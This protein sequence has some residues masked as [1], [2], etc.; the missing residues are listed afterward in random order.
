MQLRTPPKV[1]FAIEG[2]VPESQVRLLLAEAKRQSGVLTEA[3]SFQRLSQGRR[4]ARVGDFEFVC[5]SVF[6]L[7][8]VVVQVAGGEKKEEEKELTFCWC[9]CQFAEGFVLEIIGAAEEGC[10]P[11]TSEATYP[12]CAIE[13]I[14]VFVGKRYLVSVCQ[15][16]EVL[17]EKWVEFVCVPTDFEE[18]AVEDKVVVLYLDAWV[19]ETCGKAACKVTP[20]D[21]TED[22]VVDALDGQFVIMPY[23]IDEDA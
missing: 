7:E 16:S 17:G 5:R 21:K 1:T 23:E 11:V 6:G 15:C 2:F 13:N 12:D 14:A 8:S 20:R 3:M 19:P 22:I 18:F 9:T 4:V 10:L